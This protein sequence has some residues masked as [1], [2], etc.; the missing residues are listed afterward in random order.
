[1][2]AC[3]SWL[4]CIFFKTI[5][6]TKIPTMCWRILFLFLESRNVCKYFRYFYLHSYILYAS[7]QLDAT[8]QFF[9]SQYARVYYL[10][11]KNVYRHIKLNHR[12]TTLLRDTAM[13]RVYIKFG[14]LYTC[15]FLILFFFSSKSKSQSSLNFRFILSS[16]AIRFLRSIYYVKIMGCICWVLLQH[17]N[18]L[19]Y[20]LII[21]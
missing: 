13:Y 16:N 20:I 21:V 17:S 9:F 12:I 19:S 18:L 11:V 8:F 6:P 14:N 7:L 5:I 15:V 3:I 1:M 4:K 10:K 2:F